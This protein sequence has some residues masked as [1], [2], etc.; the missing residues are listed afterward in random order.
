M[1]IRLLTSEDFGRIQSTS[2]AKMQ[3]SSGNAEWQ[4]S[5]L[6]NHIFKFRLHTE[7]WQA[8]QQSRGRLPR[9]VVRWCQ[10]RQSVASSGLWEICWDPSSCYTG[11]AKRCAMGDEIRAVVQLRRRFFQ[12][13]RWRG[14]VSEWSA[15]SHLSFYPFSSKTNPITRFKT[16]QCLK[17]PINSHKRT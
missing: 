17:M 2:A 5:R 9:S 13:L 15:L 1:T 12:A 4:R 3:S 8:T 7:I 11:Q 6:R 10:W 16:D 14:I